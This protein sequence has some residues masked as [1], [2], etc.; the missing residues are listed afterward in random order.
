MSTFTERGAQAYR[1][2][3]LNAYLSEIDAD[4]RITDLADAIRA[5]RDRVSFLIGDDCR[6]LCDA[7]ADALSDGD[8]LFV[9]HQ[10]EKH[11]L[12]M[13]LA[14]AEEQFASD[15]QDA[16]EARSEYMQEARA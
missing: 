4:E 7:V 11:V 1:D 10:A 9:Q 13:I 14:A 3:R 16:A 12:P 8:W 2:S 15:A 6:W 5:D